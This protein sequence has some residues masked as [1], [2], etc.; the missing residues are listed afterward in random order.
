MNCQDD[1][2]LFAEGIK[3]IADW[4]NLESKA[5]E[6]IRIYLNVSCAF[7][8]DEINGRSLESCHIAKSRYKH[9]IRSVTSKYIISSPQMVH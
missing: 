6:I 2:K 3:E 8:C 4:L 1:D 7:D 5:Q 9:G